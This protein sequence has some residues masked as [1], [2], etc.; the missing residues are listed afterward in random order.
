MTLLLRGDAREVL[1]VFPDDSVNSCVTSPPY[2]MLR[3]YGIAGQIGR[4]NAVEEYFQRLLN[5][6]DEVQ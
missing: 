6:F 2:W 4:E 3:D 5:I 1:K